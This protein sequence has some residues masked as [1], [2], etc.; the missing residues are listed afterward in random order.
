MRTVTAT[1]R[2]RPGKWARQEPVGRIP[3]VARLLA[4]AHRLD[5]LLRTG[6]V[7]NQAD[8]A[9]LGGVTRARVTQILN[10]L[11]LAPDIQE[12]ILT[13]PAMV[14]GRDRITEHHIRQLASLLN[15]D[16]QRRAWLDLDMLGRVDPKLYAWTAGERWSSG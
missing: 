14:S 9:E 1:V 12:R 3:R 15:W 8:L 5:E 4:L 16:D 10:L 2:L 6:A 13:L 11:S 7:R